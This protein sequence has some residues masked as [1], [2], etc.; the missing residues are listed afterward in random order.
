MNTDRNDSGHDDNDF[1]SGA[2]RGAADTM[3][4]GEVDDLHVSFGVVRDRVRRRRVAKIG[5]LTGASLALVGVLAFGA[6]Q[7][8]LLD[9]E[10]VLPGQSESASASSSPSGAATQTPEPGPTGPP[11]TSVIQDRYQ[12][13]WIRDLEAGLECGMAVA[14]L[15]TTATGWSAASAGDIYARTFDLDGTPSTSWG[16]SALVSGS[17]GTLDASPVLV[18]SQDGVVVDL[19]PNVFEGSVQSAPLLSSETGDV[20]EAQGGAFTTCAP[21]DGDAG[22]IFQ[23]PL[24]EGDYEVHVVAFP[25]VASGQWATAVSAPVSV[26]LDADGAHTAT[27]T[28]GD[29]A[30]I[31]PPE[32]AE[33]ELSRFVLDRSTDR[34]TAELTQRGYVTT[35]TPSVT[36]ECES[37]DPTDTVRYELATSSGE[38]LRSGEVPCDG[39]PFQS[40]P[41]VGGGEEAVDIRLTDVPDGVAR[42]WAVLAPGDSARGDVAGEC[43][44]RSLDMEYDPA[45]APTEAAGAA[46]QAIVD[47]ARACDSERLIQL[48]TDDGTELMFSVE[49]PE[50]VFGLPENDAL[51]YETIV[52]LLVGTTGAADGGDPGNE[53]ITWP[54]VATEEFR[55][56]DEAWAEV[57]ESG[58]LTQAEAEAQRADE[59]FGYTGMTLAIDRAGTWRYYSP[60]SP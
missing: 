33:G 31:E 54:R 42:F 47:A 56:S 4:G 59:T 24:P 30:T 15:E 7:T 49:T 52:R 2:L 8:P 40:E 50:Q 5:G 11:A 34:V 3:P 41:V 1:L 37:S 28:R 18:W 53:T 29:D 26:R 48:A 38:D 23:T 25:Q 36:A 19:G 14:D 58:L 60:A 46:A 39:S 51:P 44:A 6:T 35:G 45:N 32:P 16:M 9:R 12:P 20:S 22:Q 10:P 21:T 17:E 27:G 57:V 13:S 55:D 43:S